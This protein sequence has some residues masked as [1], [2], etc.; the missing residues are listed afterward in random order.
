[1]IGQVVV[2]EP[3]AGSYIPLRHF[4]RDNRV[5]S[6]MVELRRDTYLSDDDSLDPLGASRITAA[7]AVILGT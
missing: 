6:V 2:N 3:F 1:M 4:G 7:L 5:A